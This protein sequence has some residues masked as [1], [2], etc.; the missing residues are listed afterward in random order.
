MD[1]YEKT[2]RA[3]LEVTL[4]KLKKDNLDAVELLKCISVLNSK[5]IPED[6]LIHI[7][8]SD[9]I[10]YSKAVNV[11][12]KYS[13]IEKD[14]EM[15]W[16]CHDEI[17]KTLYS[18]FK[19]DNKKAVIQKLNTILN[20]RILP[21]DVRFLNLHV[22]KQRGDYLTH[23]DK[24][25]FHSKNF[26]LLGDTVF[27][28]KIRELE[29]VLTN[30]RKKKESEKIIKD[31]EEI[32]KQG[33][34]ISDY[35]K[36]R[37][38]LMKSTYISWF[39]L[40]DRRAIDAAKEAEKLI[41][42]NKRND[43][44]EDKMTLF[45]R[46][47][48]SYAYQ[49]NLDKTFYYVTKAENLYKQGNIEAD[50]YYFIVRSMKSLAYEYKGDYQSA[51]LER[52][53]ADN[54]QYQEENDYEQGYIDSFPTVLHKLR[55]FLGLERYD[56]V[57]K[58]ISDIEKKVL[59]LYSEM[60]PYTKIILVTKVEA[61]IK[62]NKITQAKKDADKLD[63]L[64]KAD[65]EKTLMSGSGMSDARFLKLKGDIARSKGEYEKALAFYKDAE[66]EYSQSLVVKSV[67][68]MSD[69]YV[70]MACTCL[71]A[72]DIH[73][74]FEYRQ[75]HKELFGEDHR[76]YFKIEFYYTKKTKSID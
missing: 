53:A 65:T 72:A 44:H 45:A 43:I 38:L 7:L 27:Q 47:A 4:E 76:G 62:L 61:L 2:T 60:F 9:K 42:K 5:K 29:L 15:F 12:L 58:K 24:L 30:L 33:Q 64:I 69:L 63:R 41:N 74:A 73:E 25:F 8:D 71:D 36:I 49:G 10:R 18:Y 3:V 32:I 59:K 54:L 56:E 70:S 55:I 67:Q 13:L 17:Q 46:L 22:A 35:N 52:E 68:A 66:K 1:N 57:L 34:R 14:G 37:Y 6:L 39:L 19:E 50:G 11:L 26:S 75:K 21:D 20:N 28:L 48:Q 31:I 23:I 51:L 40:D 16:S